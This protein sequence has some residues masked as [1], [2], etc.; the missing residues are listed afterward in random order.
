[1][2]S[3]D[4]MLSIF[5]LDASSGFT[6]IHAHQLEA[7]YFPPLNPNLGALILELRSSEITKHF[8]EVLLTQYPSDHPISVLSEPGGPIVDVPL[9]ESGAI[10]QVQVTAAHHDDRMSGRRLVEV[11]SIGKAPLGE[12]AFVPIAIGDDDLAFGCLVR[13]LRERGEDVR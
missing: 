3:M 2:K 1:M 10:E 7:A 12:L 8:W 5:E 11:V 4:A 9:G 6:V 13:A